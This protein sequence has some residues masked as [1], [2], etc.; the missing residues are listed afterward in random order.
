MADDKINTI[1]IITT[2]SFTNAEMYF[3]ENNIMMRSLPLAVWWFSTLAMISGHLEGTFSDT[4]TRYQ[5]LFVYQDLSVCIS[6]DC[7]S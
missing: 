5:H 2:D 1:N 4:N 6:R 7:S 3:L